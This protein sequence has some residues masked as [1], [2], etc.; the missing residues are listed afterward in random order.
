[1]TDASLGANSAEMTNLPASGVYTVDAVHSTIGFVARHL[2]ASKVRGRFTDFAAL[3][4][5]VTVPRPPK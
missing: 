5:L 3:S 1:M 4:R 2:V